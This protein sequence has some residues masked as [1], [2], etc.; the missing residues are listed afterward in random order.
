MIIKILSGNDNSNNDY[1]ISMTNIVIH[2]RVPT[3]YREYCTCLGV[4]QFCTVRP[5]T[6]EWP[7][8]KMRRIQTD[9]YIYFATF[10]RYFYVVQTFKNQRICS[11]SVNAQCAVTSFP[12][13]K[14]E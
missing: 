11:E 1:V 9:T 12:Y 3:D 8:Y 7:V 13:Q 10:S 2:E 5:R 4:G 14:H 6:E